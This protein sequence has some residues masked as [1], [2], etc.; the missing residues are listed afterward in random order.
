MVAAAATKTTWSFLSGQVG[1]EWRVNGEA[2]TT[3]EVGGLRIRPKTDVKIFRESQ[4]SH[5]VDSVEIT[6]LSLQN[7]PAILLWHRPGDPPD[8]TVQLPFEFAQT[9]VASTVKLDVRWYQEW[10]PYPEIM[11]LMLP[12]GSDIQILQISFISFNFLEKAGTLF[13]SYWTFDH[14][15]PYSINFLWGPMLTVSPIAQS[16]MYNKLPPHGTYANSVWY[17]LLLLVIA[18]CIAWGWKFKSKR[19]GAVLTIAACIGALWILSDLRMGIETIAY[20]R[21]DLVNYWI[22]PVENRR[23]RERGDIPVFIEAVKPLLSDRA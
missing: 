8:Q 3:A 19:N 1:P 4:F 6:Y 14:L 12:A 2:A 17:L 21:A 10:T 7:T 23:F 13:R 18:A 11:G 15:S 20:A 5:A 16:E 22:Q 9:T